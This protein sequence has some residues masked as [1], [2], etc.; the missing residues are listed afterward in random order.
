MKEYHINL[1]AEDIGNTVILPGDPG[2]TKKIASHMDTAEH[3]CTSREYTTYTGVTKGIKVSTMSTGMGV[4]SVAIGVEELA[5]I[6]AK[7]LIRLGTCGALQPNIKPGSIIVVTGAVRG[8]GTTVEYIP[9]EYPAIADREVVNALIEG[10]KEF[11]VDPYVGI[12]RSHDA[13]YIES[14]I[15]HEGWKERLEVWTKAN[16]LAIENESSGLFVVGGLRKL[17]CGTILVVRANNIT[18]EWDRDG[19][20]IAEPMSKA[21]DATLYAARKLEDL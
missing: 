7:N 4:P 19:S 13:F 1:T 12:I 11:G 14:L 16:V 21:I 8:D 17:R 18:G 9:K 20:A 2:R 5:N 10:C 6:G 15:A 3:V